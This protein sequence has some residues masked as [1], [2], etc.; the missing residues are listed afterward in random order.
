MHELKLKKITIVDL[1]NYFYD[2][3]DN[4]LEFLTTIKHCYYENDYEVS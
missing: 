4:M 1:D 2:D 3:T